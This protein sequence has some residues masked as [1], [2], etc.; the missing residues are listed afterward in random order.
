MSTCR[1]PSPVTQNSQQHAGFTD[2]I[3]RLCEELRPV[4][5]RDIAVLRM[6]LEKV[7]LAVERVRHAL[8]D[9]D[10][11]LRAVHDAD[12][13]KFERVHAPREH[14]ECVRARIHQVKLR[15]YTNRPPSLWVH[16]PREL[17]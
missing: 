5:M 2:L 6:A 14:I 3:E 11:L 4:S 16:G 9:V 1:T 8:V 17:Q 10:V 13:A 7:R 15:Q 12:E